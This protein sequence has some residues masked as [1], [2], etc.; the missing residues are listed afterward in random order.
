MLCTAKEVEAEVE[1]TADDKVMLRL[2]N[3]DNSAM[4]DIVKAWSDTL[5]GYLR[6][7]LR[8]QALADDIMQET[9]VTVY[10]RRFTYKLQGTFRSWIFNIC[11]SR[12]MDEYRSV[13][14]RIVCMSES[15]D[16]DEASS[17]FEVTEG[18]REAFED[19]AVLNELKD[20]VQA[21]VDQ[22]SE[23]QGMTF[24]LHHYDGMTLTEVAEA[25]GT[26]LPTAKSRYRLAKEA[27]RYSLGC[28]G[29]S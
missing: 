18:P 13:Q 27:L 7:R 2:Q 6:R 8:D 28:R 29:W 4:T 15:R 14:S 5:C 12:L 24:L 9:F 20:D 26:T 22:M 17:V 21:V 11:R 16:G 19:K 10:R 1:L 3:H 23:E 25:T